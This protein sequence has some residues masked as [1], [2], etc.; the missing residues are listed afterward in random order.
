MPGLK[1]A[2]MLVQWLGRLPP[3]PTARVWFPARPV[4][5]WILFRVAPRR[6]DGMYNR[7]LVCVACMSSNMDYIKILT[8][9]E[10]KKLQGQAPDRHL[11]SMHKPR[12]RHRVAHR[13]EIKND[14]IHNTSLGMRRTKKITKKITYCIVITNVDHGSLFLDVL[15]D[16][17]F[18]QKRH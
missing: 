2:F 18:N 12:R 16:I 11:P 5:V 7:G 9:A 14:P 15:I 3:T 6:S 13:R 4:P 17:H 8:L 1:L 10:E